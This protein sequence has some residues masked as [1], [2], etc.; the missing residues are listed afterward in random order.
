MKTVSAEIASHLSY[1]KRNAS[2]SVPFCLQVS[3]PNP[4]AHVAVVGGT[5]GNESAGV[6]AIV[7]LH[8]AFTNGEI[9][10][11]RGKISFLLGNPKAYEKD[12]RYIDNDLNRAFARP[13]PLTV[14]GKRALE[15]KAF[16][17]DNDDI[18][19]L[20]DLHSVSIG[21]FRLLVYPAAGTGNTD[22]SLKLSDI[23]IHFA[24]YPGHM[25]GTLVVAAGSYDIC[26]L[27][28][29]CGNHY[30]GQAVDTAR[31]HI[32]NFLVHHQIIGDRYL[33]KA[34][35]PP[36]ITLYESIQAIKPHTGF[37]FLIKDIKTGTQLSK[38]RKYAR[39]DRGFH[40]APQDCHVVVPSLVVR[41]TDHDAGF[42]GM[43]TVV[44]NPEFHQK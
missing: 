16:L 12:I 17:K 36:K 22:L 35:R 32:C 4:G 19:A 11:N 6:K 41:P 21:D 25:P 24:F 9:M 43:R 20:L 44:E 2:G 40:A 3:S 8:R 7:E 10:P 27:I 15:I 23:P 29:E 37:G 39:D 18:R 14:E 33:S 5:H 31:Q 1:F 28:V 38:G 42:L 13:D 34:P 26:G 30:D